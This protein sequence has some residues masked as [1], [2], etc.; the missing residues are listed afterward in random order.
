MHFWHHGG[1]RPDSAQSGPSLPAPTELSAELR[2]LAPPAVHLRREGNR[3]QMQREGEPEWA[4]VSLVRLFPLGKPDEWISVLD[5]EGKEIGIL[6]HLRE[7]SPADLRCAED[8]LRRRYLVPEIRRILACRDRF[9]LV[10]W[11]VR[12]DRGRSTFLTRNL[13]EQVQEP[14]PRRLTL[15]D[16]EGNRYDVPD[17]DALDSQSRKWLEERL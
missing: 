15:M 6:E 5:K 17:V 14:L 1:G 11:T 4:E 2:M 13:R 16:V 7:L 12:T 3:L 9:D 8:E 10:E